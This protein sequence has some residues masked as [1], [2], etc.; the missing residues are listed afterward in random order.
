MVKTGPK[1]VEMVSTGEKGEKSGKTERTAYGIYRPRKD[2]QCTIECLPR[3]EVCRCMRDKGVPEKYV[4]IV[5]DM[6]EGAR[7]RARSQWA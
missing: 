3:Q 4:K 2:I 7:T 5:Q 6:Y 1:D